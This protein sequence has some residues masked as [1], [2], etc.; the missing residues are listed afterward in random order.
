METAILF[1]SYHHGN[2]KKIC[3]AI[4]QK[5]G[6]TLIDAR[7]PI[8]DLE[9]YDLI[10]LASGVAYG[11]YYKTITDVIRNKLPHNKNVFFIYTCGNPNKDYSMQVKEIAAGKNCTILGVYGCKGYDTYGP[12]KLI[13]GINKENPTAD[14]INEAIKFFE[15]ILRRCTDE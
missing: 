10:G 3:D 4:G 5:Y 7:G 11:K 1:E 8:E 2:T 13:G 9:K 15:N 12:L 6:I 14:E